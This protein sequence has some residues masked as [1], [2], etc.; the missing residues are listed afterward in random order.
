[1]TVTAIAIGTTTA[2]LTTRTDIWGRNTWLVLAAMPLV[3]PSYMAALTVIGATGNDGLLSRLGLTIPTPYG[4]WGA[5]LALSVFLA[6]LAHLTIVPGLLVC[7]L[8][9]TRFLWRPYLKVRAERVGR[10]EGHKEDARRLEAE[11]A[12]RLNKVEVELAEA[13]RAGSAERARVR[14]EAV[15]SEQ[16]ILAAAQ[17][18]A[19]KSLG[20]AR[21]RI[22]AALA[23]ERTSMASRAEA[24]GL[25]AAERILGRRIAA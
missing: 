24:L 4:F 2:W 10:V 25:E 23:A 14:S 19:Q 5:W 16:K 3:I 8:I 15:A 11:A 7:M 1:V 22:E 21:A 18:Q 6:P 9:L 17:A 12:A 20:E 13:R